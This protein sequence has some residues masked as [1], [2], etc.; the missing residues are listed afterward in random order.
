MLKIWCMFDNHTFASVDASSR[1]A[2]E[3]RVRELILKRR[4]ASFF[5]RDEFDANMRDLNWH[6]YDTLKGFDAWLAR[7]EVEQSFRKMM[8]A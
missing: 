2:I 3:K 7:F 5:V 6:S 4:G 8:G 1:E